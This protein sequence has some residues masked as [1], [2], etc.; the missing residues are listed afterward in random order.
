MK[1]TDE[2]FNQVKSE[3]DSQRIE[4]QGKLKSI[5]EDI[6]IHNPKLRVI[7]EKIQRCNINL[8][9]EVLSG[10]SGD[11]I[12]KNIQS[13]LDEKKS[14]MHENKIKKL[15]NYLD[16]KCSLCQD[17][18]IVENEEKIDKY[19]TCFKNRLVS[20]TFENSNIAQIF[21]DT[22]F[23]NFNEDIFDDKDTDKI[24]Q[25]LNILAIKEMS[26]GFVENFEDKKMKSLLFYGNT[27]TGK[28]YMA[29]CIGKEI[30]RRG[31]TLLYVSSV[32]LFEKLG[33]YTFSS[34]KK[35]T[36]EKIF[37]DFV[38]ES[39]LLIIDD[40]GTEITNL[41][42]ISKLNDIVNMRMQKRL[43]TIIST[44]YP[45]EKIDQVY[46]RRIY[47]RL[48]ESYDFYK[49]IGEDLRMRG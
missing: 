41:F 26:Q 29:I 3:Y 18:G 9:K 27:G 38:Y 21:E 32:E 4:N 13:L 24:S 22:D 37:H 34:D 46:D 39:D 11:D 17:T 8:C 12:M 23:A 7:D 49:F 5:R 20:L 14:Y 28:T 15:E 25:R 2:I 16:Y 44:N 19:C 40:L 36:Q 42:V 47:S 35:E 48:E 1:T 31:Y 10:R 43:K 45:P 30:I 33:I 6:Y